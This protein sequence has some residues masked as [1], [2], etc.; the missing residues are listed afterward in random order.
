MIDFSRWYSSRVRGAFYGQVEVLLAASCN[1]ND[2]MLIITRL[3]IV[4]WLFH[5][6]KCCEV[7]ITVKSYY[8]L[9]CQSKIYH[10]G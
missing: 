2:L 3:V 8:D 5:D 6:R 10:A 7:V 1:N 4:D 9:Y